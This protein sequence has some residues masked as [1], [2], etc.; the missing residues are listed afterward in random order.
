MYT[1]RIVATALSSILS[2]TAHANDLIVDTG[3]PCPLGCMSGLL[4]KPGSGIAG[5]FSLAHDEVLTSVTAWM[6]SPT[7][8]SGTGLVL[9]IYSDNNGLPG[10]E[11]FS[12]TIALSAPTKSSWFGAT[13]LSLE[14]AGGQYWAAF[15]SP[16]GGNFSTLVGGDGLAGSTI[17]NRLSKYAYLSNAEWHEN[18]ES[19]FGLQIRGYT[20]AVPEPT[21]TGLMLLGITLLVFQQLRSACRTENRGSKVTI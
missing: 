21:T 15:I 14:L 6:G 5:E 2:L 3:A 11:I 4:F 19:G 13:D 12:Q 7:Y 10:V 18:N 9:S 20:N 16:S 1:K 17:P 8:S